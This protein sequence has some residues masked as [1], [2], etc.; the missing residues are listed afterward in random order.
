MVQTQCGLCEGRGNLPTFT[1]SPPEPIREEVV[2]SE[3]S[4]WPF[5]VPAIL[6]GLFFLFLWL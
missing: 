1:V 5:L 4:P 3:L 2:T 6:F